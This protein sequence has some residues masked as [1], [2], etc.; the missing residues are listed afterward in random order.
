LFSHGRLDLICANSPT[1]SFTVWSN[2]GSGNFVSNTTYTVGTP[3]WDSPQWVTTADVNGDGKPDIICADTGSYVFLTVWT[4][5]GVGGF[6]S[7]PLPYIS[8]GIS[9]VVAADVNG[10]GWPDLILDTGLTVLTNNGSGGFGL[11]GTYPAGTSAYAVVAA[12]VNGD[13][14]VDLISVNQGNNTLTVLT[15]NGSGVFGSNAT[16]NVGSG[17]ESLTAADVNGDGR[18]DLISGDWNDGTLTVL[19]NAATFMPRL[20]IKRSSTNLI[21]SWP[22]IWANWTLQ[23][24]TNLAAGSWNSYSGSIGNDGTTKTAADSLPSGSRFFRLSNP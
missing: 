16:L 23:Q 14:A 4:N 2:S 15:N 3:G 12:D 7:A 18:M 24:N 19:T 8:S 11:S 1:A 17:P 9:C 6:A 22:A 10:D 5:N 20:T 13:E 21:V